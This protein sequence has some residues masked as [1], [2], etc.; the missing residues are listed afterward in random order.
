MSH[1]PALHFEAK[2]N[3]IYRASSP[4]PAWR[5]CAAAQGLAWCE[6]D[7]AGV[8]TKHGFL[9]RCAAVLQFPGGFGGNWDALSDSLEDLSW[10]PVAGAVIRWEN[11]GAFAKEA[12][13]ATAL[14]IFAAAASYWKQK[15]RVFLVLMEAGVRSRQ[16]LPGWPPQ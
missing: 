10:Q 6:L 2:H 1:L 3:G 5:S 13:F 14:E 8:A 7:L 15:S 9:D 12:D 16:T 4:L 11:A